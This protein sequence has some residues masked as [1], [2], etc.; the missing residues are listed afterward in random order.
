MN[1]FANTLLWLLC[2]GVCRRWLVDGGDRRTARRLPRQLCQAA[3]SGERGEF[4]SRTHTTESY[5][6]AAMWEVERVSKTWH[7][8]D[9]FLHLFV[10]S[11]TKETSSSQRAISQ[12]HHRYSHTAAFFFSA[13]VFLM[14]WESKS[15][16]CQL[17]PVEKKSEVKKV[18]PERPEHLPQRDQ[19]R[20]TVQT[21]SVL[22]R[23]PSA[24]S[25]CSSSKLSAPTDLF[26]WQ[27]SN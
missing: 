16:A 2:S 10:F 18:P 19:D 22:F 3:R 4:S 1:W 13:L 25:S 26:S 5:L 23:P 12:T 27:I 24:C 17:W 11:E 21:T 8:L 9:V 7:I 15:K 14:I 20:G 6:F